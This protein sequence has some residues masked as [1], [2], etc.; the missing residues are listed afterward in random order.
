[1]EH[2]IIIPEKAGQQQFGT[3]LANLV[4]ALHYSE[5]FVCGFWLYQLTTCSLWD[6]PTYRP[7]EL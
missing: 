1:M 4:V 3:K 7:V 6:S 2:V 5:S